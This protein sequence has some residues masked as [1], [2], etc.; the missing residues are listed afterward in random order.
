[1]GDE[2]LAQRLLRSRQEI[3]ELDL[4]LP[5]VRPPSPGF[6]MRA[7]RIRS[8]A[9]E[10]FK[11]ARGDPSEPKWIFLREYLQTTVCKT[12]FRGAMKI[13]VNKPR[14]RSARMKPKKDFEWFLPDTE[15]EWEEWVKSK[16]KQPKLR[17]SSPEKP[18]RSNDLHQK[19][20]QWQAEVI[21]EET[22][23]EP[24]RSVS[25]LRRQVSAT[26]SAASLVPLPSTS[27]APPQL[28]SPEDV[29]GSPVIEGPTDYAAFDPPAASTQKEGRDVISPADESTIIPGLN[30]AETQSDI[31][32]ANLLVEEPTDFAHFQ[33]PAHSTQMAPGVPDPTIIDLTDGPAKQD[34]IPDADLEELPDYEHFDPPMVSTQ[35]APRPSMPSSPPATPQPNHRSGSKPSRTLEDQSIGHHG[36]LPDLL[37][38]STRLSPRKTVLDMTPCRPQP[39]RPLTPPSEDPQR[40]SRP[41]KKAKT[42]PFPSPSHPTEPPA[43]DLPEQGFLPCTPA[44]KQK[45][46]PYV[47]PGKGVPKLD[48]VQ[49][50]ASSSRKSVSKKKKNKPRARGE[51]STSQPVSVESSQA[52]I[53]L[54]DLDAGSQGK[55]LV[56]TSSSPP[57][58]PGSPS[59]TK[60]QFS[61]MDSAGT[62]SDNSFTRLAPP[63][64]APDSPTPSSSRVITLSNDVS[65]IMPSYGSF[66]R[67]AHGQPQSTFQSS[68]KGG[69][70]SPRLKAGRTGSVFLGFGCGGYNSQFDV[71]GGAG[72]ASELLAKDID[73]M[74]QDFGEDAHDEGAAGGSQ[75]VHMR[76]GSMDI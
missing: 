30:A 28:S 21:V 40:I 2:T 19:V 45:R 64:R 49:I 38:S 43:S 63:Q 68:G 33:P 24:I 26:T 23:R 16:P 1:M 48:L 69:T 8:G 27:Q 54:S 44:P 31:D 36:S 6:Q 55:V 59:P 22:A 51:P 32:A 12:R 35:K 57:P 65:S 17:A 53:G 39:K 50:L 62:S 73:W 52:S 76:T 58:N 46:V 3:S 47:S 42:M 9:Q 75:D 56:P 29:V 18:S 61:L 20:A 66:Q 7:A 67:Y 72:M 25:D 60:S 13:G 70:D 15:Q 4:R 34:A 71:E 41:V 14:A 10:L 11:Q 37:P 74:P 5:P